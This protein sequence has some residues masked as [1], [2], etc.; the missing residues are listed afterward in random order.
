MS[1]ADKKIYIANSISSAGIFFYIDE[2]NDLLQ[3]TV[4]FTHSDSGYHLEDFMGLESKWE[5]R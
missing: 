2:E 3:R 5:E 4:L 1:F